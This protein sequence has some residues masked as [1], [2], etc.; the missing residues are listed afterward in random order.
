MKAAQSAEL[1][2]G[3]RTLADQLGHRARQAVGQA[4]LALHGI[5]EKGENWTEEGL[6]QP[7]ARH[8]APGAGLGVVLAQHDRDRVAHIGE[9]GEGD[10]DTTSITGHRLKK[11]RDDEGEHQFITAHRKKGWLF[12]MCGMGQR[13]AHRPG[14]HLVV[15]RDVRHVVPVQAQRLRMASCRCGPV[16]TFMRWISASICGLE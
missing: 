6:V 5:A 7:R 9:H 1:Q 4:E 11:A 10:E 12:A 2:R 3:R 13:G 8:K 16:S 15:Q 14:D